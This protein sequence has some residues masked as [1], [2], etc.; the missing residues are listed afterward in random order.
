MRMSKLWLR[1]RAGAESVGLDATATSEYWRG[2]TLSARV[3]YADLSAKASLRAT[4]IRPRAWIERYLGKMPVGVSVDAV[5]LRAEARTDARTSLECEIDVGTESLGIARAGERV[6]IPDV[7]VKGLVRIGEQETII[8]VND[9][10]L[11]GSRITEG[12]LRYSAKDGSIS[13][14]S[15]FNLDVAQA[16]DYTRRLVPPSV[17]EVLASFQPVTGRAQGRVKLGVGPPGWS[18]AV[19]I[20]KSD[21]A[22]QVR[23]LPGPV[24][25]ASG[26]VEIDGRKV[27]LDRVAL[28]MPAGKVLL[29]SLQYLFKDG[30]A[31]G[32]ASIDLDV[33]Q[34]LELA[35]RAL[36]QE[37]RE[38]LAAI[39]TAAGHV[40]GNVKLAF[41]R[42]TWKMGV[43]VT[44]SDA[45]LG[46]RQLP[47]PVRITRASVAAGPA[48]VTIDRAAVSL[49]DASAVASVTLDDFKGGPRARG[50]IVDGTIGEKF[51]TWVWQLAKLP[52]RYEPATP[53]RVA[54]SRISRD[55]D[56]AVEVQATAQFVAGPNVAV[57][58]GWAAGALDIRRATIKDAR[59]DVELALRVKGASFEGRYAG[60]LSSA[61][62][63]AAMKRAKMP[64][65]AVSGNLRF[66]FDR[67]QRQRLIAD[68]ELKGE[69][70][71][72]AALIGQPLRIERI[73]L[74][75]DD[76]VLHVR[77][78]T[79]DWAGQRMTLRGDLRRS[80]SGPVID[81]QLDSP[82]INLDALLPA[83][84]EIA[85]EAGPKPVADGKD[86]VSRLWPLPVT[87]R[88]ALRADSLQR[89]RYKIAPIAATLSLE[90][91]RAHL[92][93]E[94]A[95]LCGISLPLKF[96]ATPQG[97]SASVRIT[98][99]KQPLEQTAHCLSGE[100]V[101]ITGLFDLN[102]DVRTQGTL[103]ELQKN[104]AGTV[105]ADLRDGKVM[106][107]A[108]L[109]NILSM[110]NV[111]SLMKEDGPKLDAQGFPY[112]ALVVAGHFENGFFMVDE[113]SFQSDAL[114]LAANGWISITDYSSRLTVLVAPF[115]RLDE[116]V[117]KVP[118][119]GYI[120]GG[121]ITS[122][123]VGVSGDIRNPLVVPLGPRAVGSE[124]LGI[125]ER[126][127]KLPVKLIEPTEVK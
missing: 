109:G 54:A 2:L 95:Q 93:L 83:E 6:D 108:L 40:E 44:K 110:T 75:T 89:R 21:V 66:G 117:R 41:G 24:H 122:V 70:L 88:I 30:S 112:R 29:S 48:S 67:E 31:A 52:E 115:S 71:D 121:A 91:R 28:S 27:K 100:G 72:L 36:P 34:S 101:A 82:G 105:R 23:D 68:G 84:K 17:R 116:L 118:L 35:R 1:A 37:N 33:A 7:G 16:M 120:I 77:E 13:G 60:S 74:A 3:E 97:Y 79:V 76:T 5:H 98:A 15:G 9:V 65:G 127:L 113:G 18:V 20:G 86:P 42:G 106:K 58:L 11:G 125:F 63:A 10:R 104:L 85:A 61:T 114:G 51:L 87:G 99:Q 92:D 12:E 46:V 81:A 59:S 102:A 32:D 126:T 55:P 14:N 62:I 94:Q 103:T 107:F 124:V 25:L 22:V 111:V 78:A 43:D 39:E 96:E 57:D 56:G 69:A 119:L 64:S 123:P 50:A 8:G 38:A 90:E 19:D 73:D 47:G 49:L 53:I 45:T 4:N 26:A 80:E